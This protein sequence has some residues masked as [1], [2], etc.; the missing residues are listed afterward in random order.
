MRMTET[1]FLFQMQ[2]LISAFGEKSFDRGRME[3]ISRHV[4]DLSPHSFSRIVDHLLSNFRQA[5]LPKDFA[6]A[7]RGERNHASDL[8]SVPDIMK[9]DF[10]GDGGLLKVLSRD[11]PGCKTLWEAVE[12]EKINLKVKAADEKEPA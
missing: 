10:K 9:I 12:V 8:R 3:L 4:R 5:P 2:R 7:A 11:Y 6:E 1:E